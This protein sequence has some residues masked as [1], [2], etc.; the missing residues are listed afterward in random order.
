MAEV[1][2]KAEHAN[3]FVKAAIDTFQTMA[4]LKVAPGKIRLKDKHTLPYDVSG[5]IGLSGGA[6]GMVALSF[7]KASALAVVRAFS[8][9]KSI[10]ASKMVDAI[11][12]LANIVAG[13]AKKDL[14]QFKIKISLPTVI[15]GDNHSIAGPVDT[16]CLVVPF[17]F[18]GGKFDLAVSF[19]SLI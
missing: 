10:S 19:K 1:I 2:I 7:P 11:G 3:P 16:M 6:K 5:I 14:S 13:A 17:D 8:G 4:N 12:E 15:T 9:E 18:P